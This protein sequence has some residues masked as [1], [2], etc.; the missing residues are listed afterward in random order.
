MSIKTKLPQ[1]AIVGRMNVGKS[2]LFNRLSD[3][4]KSMTLDYEGVTRDVLSDTI[5]WRN[6]CFR[7]ID[8][9]GI[10]LKKKTDPV[11]E[12]TRQRALAKLEEAEV[13]LF[14]VDGKVGIVNEDRDL[15]KLI[16]KLG[17]KAILVIN[18][19]DAHQSKENQ[20]EFARLGFKDEVLLSAQHGVGV[21]ELFEAILAK[22]PEGIQK[23]EEEKTLCNVMLLGK[24]N[25][26]KSSLLNLLLKEERAIVADQPGTTREPIS[27]RIRFNKSSIKLTDTPGVR[28]KRKV[29][30]QLEQIMV[31]KALGSIDD[32]DVVLLVIDANEARIVDQE[33]KLAFYAFEERSKGLI[34]LFNK[35][36]LMDEYKR[37]SLEFSLEPY[38][39]F[40]D[41]V[42][43]LRISC[44]DRKNIR[45]LTDVI[46]AVCQRY[47][48]RFSDDE[49]T[50]LFKEALQHKPLY[51]SQQRL[52]LYR[53]N[54]VRTG[55]ITIELVVSEPKWFGPSQMAFFE[56]ILRKNA[57]L[58]GVPV[59]FVARKKRKMKKLEE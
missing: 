1:V 42:A 26:G 58:K 21:P 2:T 43:Q 39:Y 22:L 41:K 16:H 11:V 40:F 10:S 15:S 46:D 50:I 30:E 28:R 55:P 34:V 33:L 27:E 3:N 32:A 5:C 45:K 24:P 36:D 17:K 51:K 20:Y 23:E 47:T 57:D 19:I 37:D 7:L 25:V 6:T 44:K 29:D 38:D 14:M 53:A 56:G 4:V 12:Q 13:V 48:Q 18:K 52:I 31:K 8:T 49:L 59:R 35:D 54:Q 9:G